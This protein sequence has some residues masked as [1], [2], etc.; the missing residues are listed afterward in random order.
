[1]VEEGKRES[2]TESNERK[3]ERKQKRDLIDGN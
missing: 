2:W 1:M 3:F